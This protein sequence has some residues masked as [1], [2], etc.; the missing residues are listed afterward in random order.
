MCVRKGAGARVRVCVR[1]FLCYEWSPNIRLALVVARSCHHHHHHH[2]Q[3]HPT[4]QQQ[5]QTAAPIGTPHLDRALSE[6]RF[7]GGAR[8]RQGGTT[9]GLVQAADAVPLAHVLLRVH[10]PPGHPNRHRRVGR[11]PRPQAQRSATPFSAAVPAHAAAPTAALPSTHV[12]TATL[13]STPQPTAALP[14]EPT[15]AARLAARIAATV[16][17]STSL[18]TL[19]TALSGPRLRAHRVLCAARDAL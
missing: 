9:A 6:A 19:A 1:V 16:A 7:G 12:A 2:H 3:Q 18:V 4:T 11:Q 17:A 8:G 13:A 15:L 5:R 10:R 14:A